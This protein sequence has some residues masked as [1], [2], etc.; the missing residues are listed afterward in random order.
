M[1]SRQLVFSLSAFSI[2]AALELMLPP[3]S[4]ARSIAAACFACACTLCEVWRYEAARAFDAINILYFT[5]WTLPGPFTLLPFKP[6]VAYLQGESYAYAIDH[7]L[8]GHRG[9]ANLALHAVALVVS[10]VAQQSLMASAHWALPLL[11]A[12]ATALL[13]WV[14]SAPAVARAASVL[15]VLTPPL[16]SCATGWQPLRWEQALVVCWLSVQCQALAHITTRERPTLASLPTKAGEMAHTA[17][18]PL[19]LL[20]ACCVRFGL[21]DHSHRDA[22]CLKRAATEAA[23]LAGSSSPK[24]ATARRSPRPSRPRR[25]PPARRASLDSEP[26]AR[27]PSARTRSAASRRTDRVVSVGMLSAVATSE[28]NAHGRNLHGS[29]SL[30]TPRPAERSRAARTPASVR[31]APETA[32]PPPSRS[33]LHKRAR[34][35]SDGDGEE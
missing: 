25:S 29:P 23:E 20:H 30:R 4:T 14:A 24:D 9:A 1:S 7:F 16:V 28:P 2:A 11:A 8:P 12:A 15:I 32:S 10:L 19:L 22:P 6:A 13:V 35:L 17:Y 31:W 34:A 3:A 5:C 18:F 26:A 27:P 33:R 21:S